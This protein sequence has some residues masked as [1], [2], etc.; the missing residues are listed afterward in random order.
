MLC[1]YSST[2]EHPTMW[3]YTYFLSRS[4]QEAELAWVDGF[5]AEVVCRSG[6]SP[7]AVPAGPDVE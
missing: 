4:G 2:A 6:R 7:A 3:P 5:N 1:L